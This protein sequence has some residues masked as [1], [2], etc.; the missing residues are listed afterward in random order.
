MI[1]SLQYSSFVSKSAAC[2]FS[3]DYIIKKKKLNAFHLKKM[4]LDRSI[5]VASITL[6]KKANLY[7]CNFVKC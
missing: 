7:S 2:L 3:A 6:K 5:N 4:K 1:R